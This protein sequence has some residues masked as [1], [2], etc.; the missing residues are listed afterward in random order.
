MISSIKFIDA[1]IFIQ[2]WYNLRVEKF[3][4]KLD[5][6]QHCTSVLVL[7]EVCHKLQKKKYYQ[8]L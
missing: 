4:N 3:I 7:M 6:E 1:N 8:C 5:R 2:R